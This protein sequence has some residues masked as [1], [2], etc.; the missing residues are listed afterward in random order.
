M[1][2]SCT[3]PSRPSAADAG[4]ESEGR[5][6]AGL[7]GLPDTPMKS[8]W[9]TRTTVPDTDLISSSPSI[10]SDV[11]LSP[12]VST[13]WCQSPTGTAWP[14]STNSPELW[15][16]TVFTLT[17]TSWPPLDGVMRI[18]NEPSTPRPLPSTPA[19]PPAPTRFTS[20]EAVKAWSHSK[21]FS[22]GT[23]R[24]AG[25][26]VSEARFGKRAAAKEPSM[27][28]V[29]R[30]FTRA[31]LPLPDVSTT[32]E[33][34]DTVAASNVYWAS[35][36]EVR[37]GT[38]PAWYTSSS[39]MMITSL[40]ELIRRSRRAVA[41]VGE[42]NAYRRRSGVVIVTVSTRV[43]SDCSVLAS[44]AGTVVTSTA[45]W[46]RQWLACTPVLSRPKATWSMRMRAGKMTPMNGM[47]GDAVEPAPASGAAASGRNA[48]S[49]P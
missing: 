20:T 18:S 42:L 7:L 44:G 43:Q 8:G 11:A 29:T 4:N 34:S 38:A 41:S 14:R 6:P 39:S 26:A 24:Y 40:V 5:E 17:P 9:S 35:M 1:R 28:K 27:P 32:L 46:P 37:L 48:C 30:P 47:L 16:P 21:F 10:Q 13:M 19:N 45:T 49:W 23:S 33:G 3:K 25:T 15:P 12:Y 31:S 36:P 22:A 2:T